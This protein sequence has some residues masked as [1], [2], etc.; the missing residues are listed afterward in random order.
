LSGATLPRALVGGIGPAATAGD[1]M[2]LAERFVGAGAVETAFAG[3]AARRGQALSP[4]APIDME[5]AREAERL[6]ARVIGASSARVIVG[7]ALRRG[8]L[9]VAAVV[10]LLD[11]TSQE[12]SF[13][14]ELLAATLNNISQGV[15]VV[16]KD[17]RLVAWNARYV[18]IFDFP[19]GFLQV[20]RPISDV[21]RYNAL[22]GECGPGE[23]EAHVA[24]RLANM[25]RRSP[26]TYERIRP[27]G[28]VLKTIGNP[29]PGGGYVTSFTDITVERRA[30]EALQAANEG[31]EAR[32]VERTTELVKA[33]QAADE[34]TLGKT[35][36][37]A[38]ASH[39]LLQPLNAARL[40]TAVL[41]EKLKEAGEV[42][43]LAGSVERSIAAA[44]RLLRALLDISKLDAG[45]VEAKPSVFPVSELLEELVDQFM[46]LA[47]EKGLSLRC[48]PCS[49]HVASDRTLLRSVV[50]NYLS[51]AVRY[52]ARGGILLGCRRRGDRLLIEVWDTGSGIPEDKRRAIFEEF[53]RL[54]AGDHAEG[55]GLGLAIVERTAR[56]LGASIDLRSEV[57]RGSVFSVDAPLSQGPATVR[58]APSG[59]EGSSGAGLSGLRVLC[60]DNE[61][62]ILEGL[63]MLL[64][65]WGCRVRT[66]AGV[67]EALDVASC[68]TFDAALIDYHLGEEKTG[69]DA[70][71]AFA[72][73]PGAAPKLALVTADAAPEL[74]AAAERIGATVI[75]KPVDPA[76]LRAFLSEAA[77]RRQALQL[78]P[79]EG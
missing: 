76:L 36:F 41:Q 61:P 71:R 33:K 51:N 72:S 11:E 66:A 15:S 43:R 25:R 46:P 60:L 75:P 49:A 44:D 67:A 17:M 9:D 42:E 40:F 39:D 38:A 68:E 52:T 26:H 28:M 47:S 5:F 78:H 20:G 32:V 48:A 6:I 3:H 64:G 8:S 79:G 53:R 37:L 2:A 56:I 45:G 21:I 50:Q 74:A 31:L 22:N 24:R 29:M 73:A 65:A 69:L 23:V 4:D 63:A 16:D 35:K 59:L 14:R 62:K 10:G 7:S 54:H 34:A 70:V 77:I 57:G 18:E 13:S 58:P 30:Q 12:L 19:A 27:N 1:L 55:V